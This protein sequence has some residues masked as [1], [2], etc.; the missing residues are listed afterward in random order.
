[1]TINNEHK[2]YQGDNEKRRRRNT[3]IYNE[4]IQCSHLLACSWSD[5]KHQA[6]G[7]LGWSSLILLTRSEI[8]KIGWTTHHTTI[9]KKPHDH[10]KRII[11][12]TLCHTH[13]SPDKGGVPIIKMEI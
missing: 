2:Q 4:N 13:I 11:M 9:K 12:I 7:E 8:A 1:M 5:E 6:H 10:Q 3:T